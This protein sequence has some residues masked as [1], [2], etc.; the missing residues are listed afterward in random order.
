MLTH[1][2]TTSDLRHSVPVQHP[3]Q[4]QVYHCL[5]LPAHDVGAHV[6]VYQVRQLTHYAHKYAIDECYNSHELG[7]DVKV[8]GD[9]CFS[10]FY[11]Y[12]D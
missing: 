4:Q 7:N 3:R 2:V 5:D 8:V 1:V 12:N 9:T 6:V 10:T 11:T